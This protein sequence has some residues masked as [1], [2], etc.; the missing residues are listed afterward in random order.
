MSRTRSDDSELERV[1]AENR[2]LRGLLAAREPVQAV[3]AYPEA[4]DIVTSQT[5]GYASDR[6]ERQVR[7]LDTALSSIA[8]YVFICDLQGRITY[9]NRARLHFWQR[10]LKDVLG[11]NF[12]EL[13]YPH[14]LAAR[15][16][17]QIETVIATKEPLHTEAAYTS[18]SGRSGFYDYI[19]VPVFGTDGQVEAVAGSTR[20]ISDRHRVQT[21]N[22]ALLRTLQVERERLTS[23]FVQ[24][25]AFIAVLRGPQ[26]IF[27]MANPPY[28]QLVGHRDLIGRP[29]REV[30]PELADQSFFEILDEVYRTGRPFVG[31]Q[32][33]ILFQETVDAPVRERY[34]DFVYQPLIEADG[35]ISGIFAHGVDLTE[36]R[37][38]ED[39]LRESKELFRTTL[40]S[41]GDAVIATDATGHIKFMN[42][43]A[44]IL[45]GWTFTDAAGRASAE[46]FRIV[47]EQTRADVHSPI[48]R[49]LR[50]G[51][52]VGLANHTVVVARDGTEY[53]IEDSGAPI[54][55]EAG[56]LLG[57]VLVFRD[58]TESRRREQALQQSQERTRLIVEQSPLSI[59]ILAPD[60]RTLQVN[61]AWEQLWGLTLADVRDYNM[62]EDRQLA[63]K[64]ILPFILK[65]FAGESVALPPVLY[66]PEQTLPHRTTNTESPRWTQAFMYPVKDEVG[67]ILELVL[68]HEDIT[69]QRQAEHARV[70]LAAIINSS[71]D[72]IISKDL[73]GI[74]TSW[75]PAAERIYGYTAPEVLGKSKSLLIPDEMPEELPTILRRI[76]AGERIE[77]YETMRVRKDG[78]RIHLSISVSPIHDS[79]GNIVGASTI[80]RDL[81]ERLQHLR[82][83]EALNVRLKRSIQETHHR[84]KNNL[85]VIS[86]L[87]DLQ[88]EENESMVPATALARI[89]QHTR[90][91]AAVHD[92][93]TQE[94]KA[95]AHTDSISTK[96]ALER[97]IPLLQ[98]TTGGRRIE[99][100]I[101]DFRISVQEGVSL[102]L[103]IS[104]L[105]SNAVKHG[106]TDIDLTLTV[107]GT[108]AR[109]EVCDDGPGFSSGF[110]WRTAANTG[111]GLIDSTGRYD[112]KGE[113]SYESRLQ[114]GAR[115]VVTFP[116]APT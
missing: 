92:L 100:K 34:L 31:K 99:Y 75:N 32:M 3:L 37:H 71:D 65:A 102:A 26:H 44:E 25:P 80:A 94:A 95:D 88:M 16:H 28:Y 111:L 62:L 98:D 66:D 39:E 59:Q 97:L 38:V 70:H 30:F 91:L 115:V 11:K 101:D 8:D 48:D 43:V 47:N 58:V 73:D 27:E 10:E 76:K 40:R 29:V 86:A 20:D 81:S 84:V 96:A 22:E 5:Q 77:H 54:R 1:R 87:A 51:T 108:R 67:G 52:I 106:R 64:G 89:G 19:L 113:I 103:L 6:L 105:V 82:E 79:Y 41:I 56:D 9:A 49:V 12:F 57:V 104:E 93:L 74:I 46:V 107:E 114:G 63:E 85:Q 69:E 35:S 2:Y 50:E 7:L 55:N 72:A 15:I 23:L 90:N 14:E 53:P 116:I 45:T 110:D 78:A 60:G 4:E 33:L 109:L 112:L 36:Q 83:I 18:A 24:A 17:A 42:G 68:I 61:R 21:E 13:D